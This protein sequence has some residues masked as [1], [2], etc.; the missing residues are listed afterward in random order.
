MPSPTQDLW[1]YNLGAS[2]FWKPQTWLHFFVE[3]LFVWEDE[4]TDLGFRDEAFIAIV[5]PGVR[6]ALCQFE[7]VEWVV[8]VS[9]P[10]GVSDDAPDIGLFLYM[11]VEHTFRKVE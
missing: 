9:A 1:A 3:G 2:V 8:G 4:I 11:S 10:I 6:C 5:N 7:E